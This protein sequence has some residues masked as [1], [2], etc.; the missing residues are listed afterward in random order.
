MNRT[1]IIMLA[2][3]M[4][5]TSLA[6][7]SGGDGAASSEPAHE[8]RDSHDAHAAA[9]VPVTTPPEGMVWPT[10][11]P[12]RAGMSR[13]EGAVEQTLAMTQP[14]TREQAEL[15]ARTV[16]ENVAYIVRNCKLEPEPDAALHVLIGRMM[17]AT[18]QLKDEATTREAVTQLAA[19]LHDYRATFDHSQSVARAP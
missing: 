18:N 9:D 5:G 1:L 11:E 16:E 3:A 2:A 13:I 17:A 8:A 4:A 19:V 6:G 12:L 15:L 14:L 10:D 7:C